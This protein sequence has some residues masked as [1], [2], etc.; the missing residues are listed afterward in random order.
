[1]TGAICLPEVMMIK[2]LAVPAKHAMSAQTRVELNFPSPSL[3]KKE[4]KSV[5]TLTY[6]KMAGLAK[7]AGR[8]PY[9]NITGKHAGS[10]L[11]YHHLSVLEVCINWLG[12]MEFI[13]LQPSNM[14]YLYLVRH[15]PDL[16]KR[17][18]GGFI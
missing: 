17:L 16:I 2:F 18:F 7:W 5:S 11:V 9:F 10:V 15:A 6:G 12:C 13:T 4:A 1:M 14:K 3:E 8:F